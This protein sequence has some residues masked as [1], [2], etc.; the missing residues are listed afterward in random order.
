MVLKTLDA[1]G[2]MHGYGGAHK[3]RQIHEQRKVF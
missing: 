2:P 1:M 3:R